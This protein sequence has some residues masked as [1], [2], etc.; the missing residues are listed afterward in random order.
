M[1]NAEGYKAVQRNGSNHFREEW[2]EPKD[3]G[4][5]AVA[6]AE[7]EYMRMLK[8]DANKNVDTIGYFDWGKTNAPEDRFMYRN[9][10]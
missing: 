10:F 2:M 9:H 6:D 7:K 8:E 5:S 1:Y 4:L 3:R